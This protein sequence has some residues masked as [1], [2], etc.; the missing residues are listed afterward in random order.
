VTRSAA[1]ARWIARAAR[2]LFVTTPQPEL[3][4]D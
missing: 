4:I 3:T 1:R 2:R